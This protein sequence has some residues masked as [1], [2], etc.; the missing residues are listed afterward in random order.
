MSLLDHAKE[1]KAV[2]LTTVAVV[3]VLG[4]TMSVELPADK[5]VAELKVQ[6][7]QTFQQQQ[8]W[9]TQQQQYHN[10]RELDD[11]RWR[12]RSITQEINRLNMLPEYLGRNLNEQE[13]W[14]L[15][16]LKQEWSLLRD[17]E[18]DLADW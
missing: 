9:Q 2:Y 1:N 18:Q 6:L 10:T 15:E 13:L 11:I 12:M 17:R 4:G 5:K 7:A 16:T 3:A 8:Q 14:Q